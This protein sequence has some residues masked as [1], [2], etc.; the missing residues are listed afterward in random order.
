MVAF[1]DVAVPRG[2]KETAKKSPKEPTPDQVRR[3]EAAAR[4]LFDQFDSNRDGQ[5]AKTEVPPAFETFAFRR[6]D[7]NRDQ[8]LTQDEV[9]ARALASIQRESGRTKGN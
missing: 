3:A 2:S 9:F 4:Q 5:I 7:A 8:R 1:F 6:F